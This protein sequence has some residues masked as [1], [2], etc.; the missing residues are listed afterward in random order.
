[1]FATSELMAPWGE[2]VTQECRDLCPCN[3][4]IKSGTLDPDSGRQTLA[5]PQCGASKVIAEGDEDM[6]RR[7]RALRDTM[8]ADAKSI[9]AAIAE[10]LDRLAIEVLSE[11]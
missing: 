1:M 6:G 4:Y 7:N 8:R 2:W 3:P 10:E 11:R 5:C 9:G